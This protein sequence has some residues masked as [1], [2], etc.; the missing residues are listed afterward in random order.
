MA[1]GDFEDKRICYGN[2]YNTS[3]IETTIAESDIWTDLSLVGLSNVYQNNISVD[4]AN[5]RWDIITTGW[6]IIQGR[7]C[8]SGGANDSY[9]MRFMYRW[10]STNYEVPDSTITF[11]TKAV[12]TWEVQNQMLLPFK[13]RNIENDG[14]GTSKQNF[15]IQVK[16]NTDTD[17]LTMENS[18]II[19][20]K[21]G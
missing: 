2:W 15:F 18:S 5:N 21:I 16:N 7:F 8:F 19:M 13:I 11:S 12:N 3:A 17:N 4:L 9:S 10:N 6:Y 14:F 20:Y 1:I